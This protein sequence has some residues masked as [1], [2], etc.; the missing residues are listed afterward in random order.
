MPFVYELYKPYNTKDEIHVDTDINLKLKVLCKIMYK[1]ELRTLGHH[2]S[3]NSYDCKQ[4]FRT[5][6]SDNIA[7]ALTCSQ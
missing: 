1:I 5:H 2:T 6:I 4:Q 7:P 3:N